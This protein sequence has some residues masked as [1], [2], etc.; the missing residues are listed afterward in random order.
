MEIRRIYVDCHKIMHPLLDTT[1]ALANNGLPFRVEPSTKPI[2]N[3]L[4]FFL[5]VSAR[6]N[7]EMCLGDFNIRLFGPKTAMSRENPIDC[8]DSI[9]TSQ[10]CSQLRAA[11]H[12]ICPKFFKTKDDFICFCLPLFYTCM[13]EWK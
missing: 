9:A 3:S 8:D 2:G 11:K 5:A 6:R 7:I 13:V 1:S 10:N 4:L 12:T